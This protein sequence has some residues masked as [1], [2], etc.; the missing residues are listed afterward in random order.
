MTGTLRVTAAAV[1]ATAVVAGL[2]ACADDPKPKTLPSL[3]PSASSPSPST[4][5]TKGMAD[6]EQIEA[7]YKD[8][9]AHWTEAQD[10]PKSR[11]RRF[12]AKWLSDPQLSASMSGLRGLKEDN[13]RLEGKSVPNVFRV[14]IDGKRATVNDCSDDR[15]ALMRNTR[16]GKVT[17]RFGYNWYVADFKR[18]RKGWRMQGNEL[19]KQSCVGRIS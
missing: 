18:T 5:S 13:L 8:Y 10:L 4:T 11:Q 19:R 15:M 7:V 1:L 12:L 6:K 14:E 17:K 3:T 16:T 2:S 9:S